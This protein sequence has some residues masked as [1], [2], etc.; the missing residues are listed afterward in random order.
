M[1]NNTDA[2]AKTLTTMQEQINAL[3]TEV[4]Q[5]C[6][7]L[8]TL[9]AAQGGICLALDENIAFELINWE[10]YKTTSDNS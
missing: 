7:G 9:T 10:K 6:Q 4:L 2:M 8:D 1:A 5:N 3:A